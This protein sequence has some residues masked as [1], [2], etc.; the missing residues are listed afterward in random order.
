MLGSYRESEDGVLVGAIR[1]VGSVYYYYCGGRT[2]RASGVERIYWMAA[3][4]GEARR[5]TTIDDGFEN[6]KIDPKHR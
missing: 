3:A 2:T 4:G 6:M 5:S 1:V